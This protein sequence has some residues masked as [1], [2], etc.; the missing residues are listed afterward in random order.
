[1]IKFLPAF[2]W[3]IM[4]TRLRGAYLARG[5]VAY[6]EHSLDREIQFVVFET[7]GEALWANGRSAV[8]DF[9]LNQWS[10]GALAGSKPEHAFFVRCDRTTM[11]QADIDNGRL[12]CVVGVAPLKPAEF[13]NFRIGQWTRREPDP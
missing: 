8:E 10:T 12:I 1:M 13:V 9:L 5:Y 4:P 6:L 7:D 2:L 3:R 11:T